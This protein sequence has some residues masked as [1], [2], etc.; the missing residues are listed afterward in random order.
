MYANSENLI[1]FMVR[2]EINLVQALL[3]FGKDAISANTLNQTPRLKK[4]FISLAIASTCVASSASVSP[5]LSY[6]QNEA[7]MKTMIPLSDISHFNDILRIEYDMF[8]KDPSLAVAP[9]YRIASLAKL[10]IKLVNAY[11]AYSV[12][13]TGDQRFALKQ[14]ITIVNSWMESNREFTP[15]IIQQN[16]ATL[17]SNIASYCYAFN[18]NENGINL[19]CESSKNYYSKGG[20]IDK[21]YR[22]RHSNIIYKVL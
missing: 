6:D 2:M 13:L 7:M 21:K 22:E 11:D 20:M 3:N 5:R 19:F 10:R 12:F 1:Y 4:W 15:D 9:I 17:A 8:S 18:A 16:M 14:L